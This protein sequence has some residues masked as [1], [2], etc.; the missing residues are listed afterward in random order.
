[1]TRQPE[2]KEEKSTSEGTRTADRG[3]C[4]RFTFRSLVANQKTLLS[5][6]AQ[7]RPT[8]G[9]GPSSPREMAERAVECTR[10]IIFIWDPGGY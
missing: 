10:Q 4:Q 8:I 7:R 9:G 2:K 6:T 5:I 1:M 3:E